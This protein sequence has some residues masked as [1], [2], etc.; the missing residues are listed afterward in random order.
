MI[1]SEDGSRTLPRGSHVILVCA[2]A[3]VCAGCS[4]SPTFS[5]F[6]SFFPTWLL[7]ALLGVISAFVVRAVCVARHWDTA[8]PA[9]VFFYMTCAVTFTFGAYWLWVA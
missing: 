6:G 7:F 2:L 3:S 1:T 9:P 5:V 8:L 4:H